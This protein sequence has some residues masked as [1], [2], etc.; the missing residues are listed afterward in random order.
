WALLAGR[1]AAADSV[2][3]AMLECRSASGG[4]AELV[5]RR[6]RDW[7]RN[8]PPHASSAAALI[9]LVRN[10]VVYDDDDTLRLTL[11]ARARW[12]RGARVHAA[13]TRWG[14]LEL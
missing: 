1:R 4:G 12:W 6:T 9:S 11:G 7:G 13:P 3:E 2:L 10:A 5:S 8:P 14:P